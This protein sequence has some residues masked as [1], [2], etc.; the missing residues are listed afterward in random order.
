[1]LLVGCFPSSLKYLTEISFE[2][3]ERRLDD[4][5]IITGEYLRTDPSL[6]PEER[7]RL[8]M[9]EVGSCITVTTIT[10]A[11]AFLLGLMSSVPAI[12]WLCLYAFP[13]IIID[14]LYQITFFVAI[15][16]LDERRI[17]AQRTD[18]CLCLTRSATEDE[19]EQGETGAGEIGEPSKHIADRI[20]AWYAVQLMRPVVKAVVAVVF[21]AVFGF[22]AYRTSLLT[23]E[24]EVTELFPEGSY[25]TNALEN[26]YANQERTIAAEITFRHVNQSDPI[27]QQQMMDFIEDITELPPFGV[28]PPICWV[29]DFQAMRE[30]AFFDTI[31]DLPFGEQVQY[32]LTIPAIKEAYGDDIV[33]DE[34][35]NIL[36]S[37]CRILAQNSHLE[38]V[39]DKIS[40]LG[41]QRAVTNAQP[42]NQGRKDDAFFTFVN[43]YLI[44]EFYSIAVDELIFTTVSSVVAVSVVALIFIPH[45]SAVFF[46]IPMISIVYIDLLGVMQLVGLHINAVTYVCLVISV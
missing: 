29:R 27:I 40:L 5:F 28:P 37:R 10:T 41:G 22:C 46:M 18:C 42:I 14:Y 44:W 4:T 32:A 3:S 12:H 16:V 17:Q 6:A 38:E 45:W 36:A 35:G 11:S 20:M 43:L 33:V 30:T 8:T 13:T 31:A 25:V 9:Q 21:A 2:Y 23:Q 7:I 39:Q 26:L 19:E 1:M 15:L 34:D 24:F